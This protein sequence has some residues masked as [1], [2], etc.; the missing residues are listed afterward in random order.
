MAGSTGVLESAQFIAQHAEYVSIDVDACHDVAETIYDSMQAKSYSTAT[1]STHPLNPKSK[2][3]KT[4]DWIF[5]VD[6][7]N[8]SFWSDVDTN[9]TGR[10]STQ[11]FTVVLDGQEWT[12]YWSLCAAVNRAIEQD[13]IDITNPAVWNTLSDADL[14]AVFRSD[15]KEQVPML[16]ERIACMRQAGQVL[17][18]NFDGS[19]ANVIDFAAGSAVGLVNLIVKWFACFRDEVTYKGRSVRILKRAQILVSDIWACFDQA[20]YGSFH[21]IDQI[22]MFADYRV[23]QILHSLGVIKYSAQLEKH[24]RDLELL[25]YGSDRE[26]ELRGCSIWSVELIKLQI[27][28]AHPG[29]NINSVLIDFYLWDTAKE[30]Q[31]KSEIQNA[32]PCHRTRSIFY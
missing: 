10:A 20:S 21:D 9:D 26:V 17:T 28:A 25:E 29:Q 11:R 27:L 2:T 13:G 24:V 19:F 8:F 16:S 23:P 5:L 22:T 15:T 4:V 14:A 32:I 7:L 3:K 30:I 12:G 18:D 1:W 31:G 6:L